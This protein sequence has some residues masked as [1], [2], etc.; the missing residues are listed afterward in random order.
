MFSIRDCVKEDHCDTAGLSKSRTK[1]VF[2]RG[3]DCICE[4]RH[5]LTNV[6]DNDTDA[7]SCMMYFVQSR[8][9]SGYVNIE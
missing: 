2:L 9:P 8:E 4:I 5:K 3:I 6:C 1:W 7:S